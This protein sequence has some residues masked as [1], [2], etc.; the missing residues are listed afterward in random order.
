LAQIQADQEFIVRPTG[1]L[2]L[3]SLIVIGIIGAD[4]L[5]HPP[6]TTAAGNAVVA[7]EKP[8]FNALLGQTS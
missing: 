6:G 1:A 3:L 5:A 2:S 4:L 7:A 8:A